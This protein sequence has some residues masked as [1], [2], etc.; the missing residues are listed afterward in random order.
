MRACVCVWKSCQNTEAQHR[1]VLNKHGPN[2]LPRHT[3]VFYLALC[4][5]RHGKRR[6]ARMFALAHESSTSHARSCC[7]LQRSESSEGRNLQRPKSPI[8]FIRYS[9]V[10]IDNNTSRIPDRMGPVTSEV[11]ER[12]IKQPHGQMDDNLRIFSVMLPPILAAM[13]FSGEASR[14]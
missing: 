13:W 2:S 1:I 5:V 4:T 6:F 11:C 14:C 9:G 12:E 3:P 8:S 10:E 7:I